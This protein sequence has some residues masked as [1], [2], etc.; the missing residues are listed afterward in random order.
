MPETGT[1]FP[2]L[3]APCLPHP[4]QSQH[5]GY[6]VPEAPQVMISKHPEMQTGWLL[7]CQVYHCTTSSRDSSSI[8]PRPLSFLSAEAG[9]VLP[10]PL[11]SP[12]QSS[13]SLP[14]ASQRRNRAAQGA[15]PRSDR[16]RVD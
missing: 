9:H 16:L 6:S 5:Q 12:S 15:A 2:R 10:A 3:P 1:A 7:L 14:N 11:C 13:G 8:F 4:P